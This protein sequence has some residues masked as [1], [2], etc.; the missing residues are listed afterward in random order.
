MGEQLMSESQLSST[1][2][3]PR[4]QAR[5]APDSDARVALP[6]ELRGLFELHLIYTRFTPDLHLICTCCAP[7][8]HPFCTCFTPVSAGAERAA[9]GDAGGL[10]VQGAL[11]PG[12]HAPVSPLH[13]VYT[14][15]TPV[16]GP[17]VAR[18]TGTGVSW[19]GIG[20]APGL[21][22]LCTGFTP[23]TIARAYSVIRAPGG[24]LFRALRVNRV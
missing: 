17:P 14:W 13:L 10:P 6:R 1:C 24:V 3:F 15:F 19:A 20:F 18:F 16:S 22:L 5:F 21:R 23:A 9:G 8:L 11:G 7:A 12:R 4:R 2:L